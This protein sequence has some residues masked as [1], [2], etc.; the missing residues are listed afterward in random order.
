MVSEGRGWSPLRNRGTIQVAAE[1][2]SRDRVCWREQAVLAG[3][4]RCCSTT[5]GTGAREQQLTQRCSH[6][7]PPS[8]TGTPRN[9]GL[10]L[11]PISLP[12]PVLIKLR[13]PRLDQQNQE[14]GGL[15]FVPLPKGAEEHS[16]QALE[17]ERCMTW[18]C[19]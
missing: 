3:R 17:S 2:E 10:H 8:G 15:R 16:A 1:S 9:V 4:N 7:V 13:F 18:G 5:G 6:I 12:N 14:G 11:L 19:T